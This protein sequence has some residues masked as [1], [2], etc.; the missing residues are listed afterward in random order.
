ML[1]SV[2]SSRVGDSWRSR[3]GLSPQN[4]VHAD[5]N[6]ARSLGKS[7]ECLMDKLLEIQDA[8]QFSGQ[9][10]PRQ[11]NDEIVSAIALVNV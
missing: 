1:S 6:P 7:L 5:V 9:G 8:M 2:S 4:S 10:N 11:G 3:M